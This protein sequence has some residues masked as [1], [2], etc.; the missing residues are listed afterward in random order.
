MATANKVIIP[1]LWV[2]QKITVSASSQTIAL[3]G[4]TKSEDCVQVTNNATE[5]VYISFSA[6]SGTAAI[7]TSVAIPAGT[8]IAFGV[9]PDVTNANAIGTG[10]TGVIEFLVG[11]GA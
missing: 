11:K 1:T 8:V 4:L 7:A 10:T 5:T 2:P 6:G 3:V 9:A